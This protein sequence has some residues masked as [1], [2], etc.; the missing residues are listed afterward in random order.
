LGLLIEL[1]KRL[2][3]AG[4]ERSPLLGRAMRDELAASVDSEP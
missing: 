1:R 2:D 3:A 4:E